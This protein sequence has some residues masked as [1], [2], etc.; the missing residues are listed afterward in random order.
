LGKVYRQYT[1]THRSVEKCEVTGSWSLFV[2]LQYGRRHDE[3]AEE[4]RYSNVGVASERLL[5]HERVPAA[6]PREKP[7]HVSKRRE[8]IWT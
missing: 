7:W 1:Q 4:I 6:L 5:G 8:T 3:Y 2:G